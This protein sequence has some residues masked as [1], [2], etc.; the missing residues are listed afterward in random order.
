LQAYEGLRGGGS[1]VGTDTVDGVIDI[2][3]GRLTNVG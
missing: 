3:R 2:Y 1:L